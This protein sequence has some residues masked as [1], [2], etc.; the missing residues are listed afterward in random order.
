MV[1]YDNTAKVLLTVEQGSSISALKLALDQ[2]RSTDR[3]RNIVSALRLV[4]ERIGRKEDGLRD[5]VA[6]V[7]VVFLNGRSAAPSKDEIKSQLNKLGQL[8]VHL[9][10][11]GIGS[12]V[13]KEDAKDLVSR[14]ENL[15]LVKEPEEIFGASPVISTVATSGGVS[16]E[17]EVGFILGADG[18]NSVTDFA[19]GRKAVQRIID[20]LDI[21]VGKVQVG[22]A[23]YGNEEGLFLKLSPENNR[24]TVIRTIENVALPNDESSKE[25]SIELSSN[26]IYNKLFEGKDGV[27]KTAVIFVNGFI[28]NSVRNAVQRLQSKGVKIIGVALGEQSNVELIRPIARAGAFKVGGIKDFGKDIKPIVSAIIPGEL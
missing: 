16:R 27:A 3:Q 5:H 15:V 22:L 2:V 20:K 13:A 14:P 12:N 6:K 4:Q 21:G 8:G 24:D 26:D 9:V 17:M 28:D 18:P 25:T 11:I 23:V 1:T 10:V 7:L 19:L